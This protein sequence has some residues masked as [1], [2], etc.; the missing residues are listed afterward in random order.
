LET[1]E[2]E[3]RSRSG[4]RAH[5]ETCRRWPSPLRLPASMSTPLVVTC[6]MNV[7]GGDW[8]LRCVQVTADGDEWMPVR[9]LG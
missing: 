7:H 9:D 3:D 6:A 4:N 5:A 1:P 8:Q 2:D